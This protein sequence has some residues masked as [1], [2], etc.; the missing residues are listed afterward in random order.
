[1]MI[2]VAAAN[3]AMLEGDDVAARR[4]RHMVADPDHL[5]E[6]AVARGDEQSVVE[7]TIDIAIDREIAG[8]ERA[9]LQQSVAG[10]EAAQAGVASQRTF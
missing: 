9:A 10:T 2:V 3:V 5:G 8:F 7:V 6:H 4:H 1:M